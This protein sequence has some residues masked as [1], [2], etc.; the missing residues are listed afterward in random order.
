[1]KAHEYL[2]QVAADLMNAERQGAEE[3][4]PEGTRYVQFS[5]TLVKQMTANFRRI[6]NALRGQLDIELGD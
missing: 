4:K 6:A 5:D 2:G 1:M 3:D